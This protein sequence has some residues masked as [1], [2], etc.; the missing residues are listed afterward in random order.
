MLLFTTGLVFA[1]AGCQRADEV[2]RI[3]VF[4]TV[5]SESG[6]PISGTISFLPEAGTDGP[7]ATTSLIDGA[8]AFDT[9]NGPVAGK[10]RV[11]VVEQATD[12]KH[13]GTANPAQDALA[14]DGEWSFAAEVSLDNVEFE[15][16]VPDSAADVASE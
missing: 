7:A 10:Y 1:N 11:L 14:S 15:F 4:G 3:A 12:R 5:T 16:E 13:K 9:R 8:F 6:E 2:A